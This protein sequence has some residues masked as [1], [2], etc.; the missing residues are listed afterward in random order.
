MAT[1]GVLS[2]LELVKWQR[3]FI[4]ES[5]RDS[6]FKPYMGTSEMDI[7][8]VVNDL[9]AEGDSIRVP[10]V[11]NLKAA[12]V[13]G[14]QRLSGNEE[15]M[16]QYYEFVGWE[17]YR[18]A[19]ETS[20][21]DRDRTPVDL[22]ATKRPLLRQWSADLIKYQ[23][24]EQFHSLYTGT[25]AGVKYS[26]ASEA[27]KDAWVAANSDRVLFGNAI[28]N[29]SANDHSAAL[30]NVD[31][32]NDKLT[33]DSVH[34][35]KRRIRG[36]YPRI[37]PFKTGTEGREYYVCFTHPRCFRDLKKDATIAAANRDARP[38]EVGSN[39][40]FQDGDIIYSGIIFREIP[41]LE[42]G[43]H[44]T[45]VNAETTLVGVGASSSDVGA[46]FLCGTQALAFVNKAAPTPTLKE[47]G[48]YGFFKGVGIELAH[49]IKKLS[50]NN[51]SGTR[52]DLGM[53]T[54]YFSASAD[55]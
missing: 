40:I 15:L 48:D 51:G 43:N 36:A 3:E 45:S 12:G 33:A 50:W 41:E 4:M 23:L 24:I 19:I 5:A 2:G 54:C 46:N 26:A 8:R 18:N 9:K 29:H 42:F 53:M 37:T 22:L 16:D 20:K 21:R 14:N 27:V 6:G 28:S 13:T 55:T 52:K 39:P 49:G 17:Y 44:T 34:L 30:A 38:R 31:T 47:D 32:T 25:S 7:I 1:T 11:L 35:M 10:L